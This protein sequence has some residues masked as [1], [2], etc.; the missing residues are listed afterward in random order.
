MAFVRSKG[1]KLQQSIASTYVTVA[2]VIE[3]KLPTQ[4]TETY[5]NDTLDNE[6]DGIPNSPTG[7]TDGGEV[8]GS[9]FLDPS[10]A[11]H[12]ALFALLST[13]VKTAWKIV[14]CDTGA[15]AMSFT[16][17]GFSLGGTVSLKEGLKADFNIKLDGLATF[18]T[19]A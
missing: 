18:S 13:P 15:T 5:E 4:K 14:F 10:L 8:S 12:Q 7:R 19:A 17:A 1:T 3:L 6:S 11:G 16:G 9:L 2:Q